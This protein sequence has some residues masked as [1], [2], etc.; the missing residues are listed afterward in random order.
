MPMRNELKRDLLQGLLVYP[1]QSNNSGFYQKIP[2]R[3]NDTSR[4]SRLRGGRV[5]SF[6]RP[7]SDRNSQWRDLRRQKNL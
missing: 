7:K 5:D 4:I 3:I 6:S 1:A 2:V